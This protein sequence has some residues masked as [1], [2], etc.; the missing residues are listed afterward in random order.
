ML[1][2]IPIPCAVSR[3]LSSLYTPSLTFLPRL[4]LAALRYFRLHL[5]LRRRTTTIIIQHHQVRLATL[6]PRSVPDAEQ[7]CHR[8]LA[9]SLTSGMPLRL[10]FTSPDRL[11][12][13]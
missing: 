6:E 3:F 1:V 11:D 7:L 2:R 13:S 12:D 10:P 8:S 9:R 5:R 4:T